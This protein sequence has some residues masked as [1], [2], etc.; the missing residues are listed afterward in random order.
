M[1]DMS[2]FELTRII[3]R[4][5]ATKHI[6]VILCPAE[7][8]TDRLWACATGRDELRG[9]A[10]RRER[11]PRKDHGAGLKLPLSVL[12]AAMP[13]KILAILSAWNLTL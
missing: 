4:D 9:E 10:G 12:P 6:P 11:S 8:R 7:P 3:T 1:P 2:G 13:R 5:E